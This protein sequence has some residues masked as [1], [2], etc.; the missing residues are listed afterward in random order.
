[1]PDPRLQNF[2]QRYQDQNA[3]WDTGITPPEIVAV[4]EELSP[5]KVLDLGCGTGTN[6]RYLLEHGWEADGIDFVPQAIAIAEG[7][8][9]DFSA[10][11]YTLICHDVT[12]LEQAEGLRAPYDL[13][14]DI[15]C[16]H[17][18]PPEH[19]EKYAKDCAALLKPGGVF[20]LY[21]HFPT[22][23][24][25]FGWTDADVQRLFAEDFEIAAQVLSDDTTNG[26]PSGWFRLVRKA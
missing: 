26:I 15:G 12:L 19:S 14:V 10:D 13:L 3:P 17:A 8:M 21:S 6:V 5:G 18:L 2:I 4:V 16:G 23:Q 24:R 9:A 1:M 22:E 25:P 7:K 20:M 11:R